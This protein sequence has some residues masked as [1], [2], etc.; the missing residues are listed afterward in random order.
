VSAALIIAAPVERDEHGFWSHPDLPNFEE[1]AN[2]AYKAWVAAQGLTI[3][4]S[5][6]EDEPEDHPVYVSYF[7]NGDG[8]FSAWTAA[9]PVGEGWFTLAIYDTEDGPR[10]WWARRAEGGAA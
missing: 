2:A 10:W 1:G 7:D 9:A 5:D 6:L 4:H 3:T 8:N